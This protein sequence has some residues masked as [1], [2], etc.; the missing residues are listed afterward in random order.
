MADRITIRFR[1]DYPSARSAMAAADPIMETSGI[2][3]LRKVQFWTLFGLAAFG[4]MAALNMVFGPVDGIG[5]LYVTVLGILA[6]AG[7][8]AVT[9]LIE[10]KAYDAFV[11][12][13]FAMTGQAEID[14]DSFSFVTAHSR[15]RTGWEDVI[16]TFKTT[17]AV[18]IINPTGPIYIPAAAMDDPETVFRQMRKWHQTARGKTI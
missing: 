9:V 4:A 8:F 3:L 18:G 15:W 7:L 17:N 12:T 13:S 2:W 1:A 5:Y 11:K 16:E 14:A 10:R 6:V